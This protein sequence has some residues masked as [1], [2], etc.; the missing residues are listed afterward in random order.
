[1][2]ELIRRDRFAQAVYDNA[3]ATPKPPDVGPITWKPINN[4]VIVEWDKT[5]E[6][7]VDPQERGMDFLGY[8]LFRARVNNL[9]TFDINQTLP[10]ANY[11]LGKGPFGWKEIA[12]WECPK[13]YVLSDIKADS[14]SVLTAFFPSATVL[15]KSGYSRLYPK[16]ITS[17]DERD[18]NVFLIR[19]L[20][21]TASEPWRSFFAPL[22]PRAPYS[23]PIKYDSLTLGIVKIRPNGIVPKFVATDT[24]AVRVAINSMYRQVIDSKAQLFWLVD[25]LENLAEYRGLVGKYIDSV[26]SNRR[27]VDYGDDNKDGVITSDPDLT[28]TE[29]LI[30]NVDYYYRLLAYD[31]GDYFQRTPIKTN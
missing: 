21:N 13:P 1:M 16:F 19:R 11:S 9:D 15:T 7:S 23:N 4:G 17:A 25:D 29:K 31:E 8:R 2:A 3:F 30:N 10:S 6:A 5:A 14:T 24:A 27:Y 18:T 12:R 22:I 26:T 20:P 28:K